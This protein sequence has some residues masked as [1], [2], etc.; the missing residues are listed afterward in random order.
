MVCDIFENMVI[1]V[2]VLPR[3]HQLTKVMPNFWRA[4]YVIVA[5]IYIWFEPEAVVWRKGNKI[6][7]LYN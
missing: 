6:D 3:V 4:V 2:A 7:Q 5:V 1:W